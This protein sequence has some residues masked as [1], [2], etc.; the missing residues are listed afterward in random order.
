MGITKSA[1][2]PASAAAGAVEFAISNWKAFTK[3]TLRGFFSLTLPSGLILHNCSLHEREDS[4]WI[5]LPAQKFA[6]EDGTIS[7]TQIIEFT[8]KAARDR[9]QAA[10]VR[11]VER[12]LDGDDGGLA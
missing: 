9:F 4:R 7:Y 11:G 5:G 1:D 12:F 2:G 6:K 10:A 8:S 3:N